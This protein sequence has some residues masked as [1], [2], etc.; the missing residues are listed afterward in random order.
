MT[1]HEDS[2]LSALL[3]ADAER[4]SAPAALRTRIVSAIHQADAET[5]RAAA[6]PRAWQWLNMG[7]AFAM[8]VALSVTLVYFITANR[9]Q[10]QL[11]QEVV[12]SHVRSLMVAHLADVASTDQHTV[13]PWFAGKLD[14]SPPVHDLAAAG[15]PLVGGR[16]DYIN[17]HAVAALVYQ[18]RLHTIN[19]FVWPR[20]DHSPTPPAAFVAQGF[21]VT[22]WQSA[23]MQFWVVSDLNA[24]ELRQ[25]AQALRTATNG[26]PS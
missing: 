10:D 19:V 21:N 13:K 18:H 16:L 2:E 9:A 25:F 24:A 22:G 7:A 6:R 23:A 1:P 17:G 4:H 26:A 20:D 12:A 5:P 11:A 15:S 14:F 3:R 8:G